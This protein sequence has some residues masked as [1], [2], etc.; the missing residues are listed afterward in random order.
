MKKK[1]LFILVL[2]LSIILPNNTFALNKDEATSIINNL[3][4]EIVINSIN[5]DL[6]K[7]D[8][9]DYDL[10]YF[11]GN[12][13]NFYLKENDYNLEDVSIIDME[14][15]NKATIGVSYTDN[16]STLQLTKE[17]NIKYLDN[18]DKD[19]FNKAFDIIKSFDD[20]YYLQG[21][22]SINN[23]YHYGN[24]SNNDYKTS[25]ILARFSKLKEILEI[26]S[27][28]DF[29]ILLGRG[30]GTPF[31]ESRYAVISLYKDDVLYAYKEVILN[32]ETIIYV[33]KNLSG[34][35]YEKAEDRLNKYFNNKVNISFDM[36][37]VD[38][39]DDDYYS[40]YINNLFGTNETY[41]MVNLKL[42]LDNKSF[43][44]TLIEVDKKYIDDEKVKSID[45][46]TG[47]NVS[48]TSYD[49]PLDTSVKTNNV[50]EEEYIT[51]FINKNKIDLEYAYDINLIKAYD[52]N[53][54]T[55]ITNGIDV[56]IPINNYKKGD[57]VTIYYIKDD[58]SIGE[59]L[60]GEVVEIDNK[61]Y[62]KFT[63][64]HFSTYGVEKL[65]TNSS[66]N[67]VISNPNTSDNIFIYII[68]FTISLLSIGLY[69]HKKK[70]SLDN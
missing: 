50:I 28:F 35:I 12:A 58:S 39:L 26:N 63:T 57:K 37:N 9:E 2:L 44:V 66:N 13:I 62:I 7:L 24:I 10:P 3:D 23:L 32:V 21:M 31:G 11:Y 8:I 69:A 6:F 34:T 56:Y 48:T 54:V 47:I 36:S 25:T 22:N 49:V 55:N 46:K 20:N 51:K 38:T 67:E 53:Y 43:Y 40:D 30:G 5:P 52:K 60:S 16:G 1:I 59:T 70:Y 4:D 18:Y 65:N 29:E 41:N 68:T 14:T 45:N 15:S 64:T 17:V 33:D 27:E 19:T 42:N 61:L